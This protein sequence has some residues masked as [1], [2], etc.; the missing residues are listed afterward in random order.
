M[1]AKP[2]TGIPCGDGLAVLRGFCGLFEKYP[3]LQGKALSVAWIDERFAEVGLP[4]DAIAFFPELAKAG[5]IDFKHSS[6]G[7]LYVMPN[8]AGRLVAMTEKLREAEEQLSQSLAE[9]SRAFLELS[10]SFRTLPRTDGQIISG[11]GA[12]RGAKSGGAT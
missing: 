1:T 4:A 3:S 7:E 9:L 11:D 12:A 8:T 6:R 5:L 10:E 2:S